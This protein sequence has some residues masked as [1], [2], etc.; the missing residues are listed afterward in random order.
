M[1]ILKSYR[2]LVNPKNIYIIG[3]IHGD[4][5]PIDNF[6]RHNKDNLSND[7]R[8]NVLVILGDFGANFYLNNKDERFKEHIQQYP[9]TY[10]AIR[11]NHEERPSFLAEYHPADWHKEIYFNNRVWTEDRHPRIL[12]ALDEGGEYEINGKSVLII[13]GAYSIDKWYR[14]ANHWPWF[15]E[16]QLSENEKIALYKNLKSSYDYIFSHTCPYSWEFYISDL[17]L[18][19]VDQGVIDKNTE[20]FLDKIILNTKY[21]HYYFGHYHQNRDIPEQNATMLFHK[22]IPLGESLG[23]FNEF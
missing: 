14:L 19:S 7:Y 2:E 9:I 21:S 6:Y 5:A 8:E 13:P 17:F 1:P 11:G 10:F 12:Y 20:K 22:A 4:T 15:P 3:D 23:E 18:P 16:E